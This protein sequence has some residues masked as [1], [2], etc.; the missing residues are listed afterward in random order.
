MSEHVTLGLVGEP[1]EGRPGCFQFAGRA[2]DLNIHVYEIAGR[3]FVKD[4]TSAYWMEE[5][6]ALVEALPGADPAEEPGEPLEE[7]AAVEPAEAGESDEPPEPVIS[8]SE[9]NRHKRPRSE[10]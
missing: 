6:T 9:R 7:P 10:R 3:R 2:A 8:E 5:G 1:I 4:P